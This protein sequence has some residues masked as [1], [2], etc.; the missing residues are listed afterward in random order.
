MIYAVNVG[1][2]ENTIFAFTFSTGI[3]LTFPVLFDS[4]GDVINDWAVRGLPTTFII[5]RRGRIVY[6]AIGGR[7]WDDPHLLKLIRNL[8]AEPSF[9]MH[10]GVWR[11]TIYG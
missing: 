9:I 1:E 8:I 2:D 7:E 11:A 3:E 10:G 4:A 5:D 6:R